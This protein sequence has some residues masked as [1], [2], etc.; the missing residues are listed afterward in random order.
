MSE[1]TALALFGRIK[2]AETPFDEMATQTNTFGSNFDL[3]ANLTLSGV[4]HVKTVISTK[5]MVRKSEV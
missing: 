5:F 1:L 2:G 3:P 4:E